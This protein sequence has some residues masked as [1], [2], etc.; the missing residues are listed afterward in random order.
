MNGSSLS[1]TATF[2]PDCTPPMTVIFTDIVVM[3]TTNNLTLNL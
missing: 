2:Q 3:D 1:V